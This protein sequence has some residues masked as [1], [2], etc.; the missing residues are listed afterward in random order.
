MRRTR[1]D[2]VQLLRAIAAIGV[3]MFHAAAATIAHFPVPAKSTGVLQIGGYGIDLFFVISG[4]VI[5]YTSNS[6]SAG[7]FVRKRLERIVPIYWIF[8]LL[9][10]AL[11]FFVAANQGEFTWRKLG[12]SLAF[13]SFYSGDNPIVYVGW[14]LEYEML[15]YFTVALSMLLVRRPWAL[16]CAALSAAVALGALVSFSSPALRFFTAP[17]ML[18]F[19]VGII[20]GQ[21]TMDRQV[22]KVEAVSI[23][24]AALALFFGR[25]L[26][27]LYAG[28]PAAMLVLAAVLAE[29]HRLPKWILKIGDA[30]YSIYLIQVLSIPLCTKLVRV[31]APWLDPDV[32]VVF[33]SVATVLGG[34]AAYTWVE[35]GVRDWLRSRAVKPFAVAG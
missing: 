10:A 27:P 33:A 9:V 12:M 31:K 18:E 16:T 35:C 23:V 28:I 3:V 4:F 32:F 22:G 2:F 21:A 17:A 15:F 11:M 5:Y 13:V 34:V 7:E 1:L 24:C 14:T 19:L 20:I 8:T 29:R 6:A 25:H 26:R 30:S